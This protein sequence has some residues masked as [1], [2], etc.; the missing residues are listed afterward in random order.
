MSRTPILAQFRSP[1]SFG[2]LNLRQ[3]LAKHD[4]NFLMTY[5]A[6]QE[7]IDLVHKHDFDAAGLSMKNTHHNQMSEMVITS[8]PLFA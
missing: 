6:A 1:V 4:A 3:V 7:I 5:D 2:S 8:E